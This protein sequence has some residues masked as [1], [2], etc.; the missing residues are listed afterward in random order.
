MKPMKTR[1]IRGFEP[2]G[3]SRPAAEHEEGVVFDE[4]FDTSD[5][6]LGERN[7]GSAVTSGDLRQVGLADEVHGRQHAVRDAES[8]REQ[9]SVFEVRP[10][11]ELI[12]P[13]IL[14]RVEAKAAIEPELE[15]ADGADSLFDGQLRPK[16]H[17]VRSEVACSA[18]S[19][20]A[21]LRDRGEAQDAFHPHQAP[22]GVQPD[23]PKALWLALRYVVRSRCRTD[24]G[25]DLL[26]HQVDGD[27]DA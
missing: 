9:V 25:S 20:E 19:R 18:A 11:S 12:E 16:E 21:H 15:L 26:P 13:R 8:R 10:A 22:L 23:V 24:R 7:R 3:E 27:V 17:R 1:P 14:L 6:F 4:D 2:L 5:G